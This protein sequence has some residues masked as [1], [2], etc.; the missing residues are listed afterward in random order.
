MKKELRLQKN[1]ENVERCERHLVFSACDAIREL[2]SSFREGIDVRIPFRYIDEDNEQSVLRVTR[3][4]VA[5]DQHDDVIVICQENN[6]ECP[7]A[8]VDV[9]LDE[10][11]SPEKKSV[12]LNDGV[13]TPRRI[14]LALA[15]LDA[16]TG[17][18]VPKKT[19]RDMTLFTNF[20]AMH[21]KNNVLDL[22][23]EKDVTP[24]EYILAVVSELAGSSWHDVWTLSKEILEYYGI[25]DDKTLSSVMD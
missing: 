19:A 8:D 21:S 20:T 6:G 18:W 25:E 2:L 17:Y 4:F 13:A 24:L 9:E 15:V 11:F 12:D 1:M 14:G 10:D 3:V 7:A 22:S 16:L 5:E 23:K